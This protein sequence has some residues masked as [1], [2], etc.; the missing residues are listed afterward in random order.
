MPSILPYV[1]TPAAGSW[2][3]R[4]MGLRTTVV[5]SDDVLLHVPLAEVW[6]GVR[7]PGT[8]VPERATLVREALLAAGR[9]R[10]ARRRRTTTRCSPALHDPGLLNHLETVWDA[11][12]SAGFPTEIGQDR[13]VPYVFPTRGLVG[14][15]PLREPTAVHGRAGRWC[16]DT[17]TLVGPGTWTA[18]R[19]AVDAAQTAADLVAAGEH[20]ERVR[21]LPSAGPPCEP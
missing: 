21:P 12:V 17:M 18:A 20:A 15:L 6:V 9:R 3:A 19:A 10:G 11:W 2:H 4:R 8:E 13:V 1:G 7:T 5:W 14:D 16:Y